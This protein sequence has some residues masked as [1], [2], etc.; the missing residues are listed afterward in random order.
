MIKVGGDNTHNSSVV[1][2]TKTNSYE[3]IKSFSRSVLTEF[4]ISIISFIVYYWYLK[5]LLHRIPI[6][7]YLWFSKNYAYRNSNPELSLSRQLIFR[8]VLFHAGKLIMSYRIALTL[9]FRIDCVWNYFI[10]SGPSIGPGGMCPQS[11]R[12]GEA[13]GTPYWGAC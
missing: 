2:I 12:W 7:D 10:K 3:F 5:I 13:R 9:L 6:R 8:L 1:L 11:P 4:T